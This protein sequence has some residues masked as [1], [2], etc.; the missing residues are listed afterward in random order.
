[1]ATQ[2]G[3]QNLNIN[4][5]S[6][7]NNPVIIEFFNQFDSL[8]PVAFASAAGKAV[9]Y[10]GTDGKLLTTVGEDYTR[11]T[12]ELSSL[13]AGKVSDVV[14]GTGRDT[15]ITGTGGAN[16][17][18]ITDDATHMVR[19]GG[20]DDVITN[21]GSGGGDFRGGAGSDTLTGGAGNER[22]SGGEG[23]DYLDGG[24][25]DDFLKGGAGNDIQLGGAGNDQLYGGGGNDLLMGGAGDD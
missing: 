23:N 12:F 1:M 14:I 7:P 10:Q 16:K 19:L 21:A 9:M 11:D 13:P 22:L 2:G 20:G 4:T 25:G 15:A 17:I 3:G 8:L 24:A 18:F 5:G 6:N